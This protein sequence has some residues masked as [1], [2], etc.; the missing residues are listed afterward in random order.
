[1]SDSFDQTSPQTAAQEGFD[2]AWPDT[3]KIIY[4]DG[5]SETFTGVRIRKWNYPEGFYSIVGRD[6]EGTYALHRINLSQIRR[7]VVIYG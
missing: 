5:T 7:A 1:M 4:T 3:V 2:D 6:P